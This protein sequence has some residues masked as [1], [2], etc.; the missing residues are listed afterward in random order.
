MKQSEEKCYKAGVGCH[1]IARG[2]GLD[3]Q[4]KGTKIRNA[5]GIPKTTSP[6]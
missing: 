1:I 3:E 4:I 6:T 5:Q 2:A